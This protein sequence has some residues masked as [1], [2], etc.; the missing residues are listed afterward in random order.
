MS[1]SIPPSVDLLTCCAALGTRSSLGRAQ[2]SKHHTRSGRPG[3]QP[4]TPRLP[5]REDTADRSFTILSSRL[6]W[7]LLQGAGNVSSINV[8]DVV[9]KCAARLAPWRIRPL[10]P[11]LAPL[12]SSGRLL[13]TA[14]P[15]PLPAPATHPTTQGAPGGLRRGA[16]AQP[17]ERIH[18]P[19]HRARSAAAHRAGVPL[20]HLRR[21]RGARRGCRVAAAAAQQRQSIVMLGQAKR[22]CLLAVSCRYLLLFFFVPICRWGRRSLRASWWTVCT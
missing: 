1:S 19:L 15:Y 11:T 10:R 12:P 9:N 18:R 13:M 20:G 14:L 4:H 5:P 17:C 22:S 7:S 3:D 2:S 21:Q 6:C 16:E 8:S